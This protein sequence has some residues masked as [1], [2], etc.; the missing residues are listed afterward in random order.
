MSSRSQHRRVLL[1]GASGKLG[2]LARAVWHAAAPERLEIVPVFRQ[3]AEVPGAVVWSPDQTER[4]LPPADAVLALWGGVPGAGQD[5]AVNADLALRADAVAR[6]VGADRVLHCSSAAVYR[7]AAEPLTEDTPTDP[8]SPYGRA[9]AEMEATIAAL[10]DRGVRQIVLRIGNVMGAD[11]LGA[12]L[13]KGGGITL[14][15]FADE[16]GP[17]RSYIAA[18]D[19]AAALAVLSA[20][21]LETVPEVL[22]IAA[23]KATA[24]ADIARAAGHDV[25]WRDAPEAAVPLVALDTG[26]L[27]RLC[28]LPIS[29]ADATYLAGD[30]RRWEHAL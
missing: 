22:N 25:A 11:S 30:A 4:L 1:L 2:R 24:M 17:R 13:R 21:P 10:P 20:A 6:A 9:K 28:P 14:D 8:Q 16:T 23:P 29:A 26:R 5:L 15:R 18:S 3:M 12:S 7:P 27:A 19:F